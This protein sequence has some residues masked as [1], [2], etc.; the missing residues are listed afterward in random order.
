MSEDTLHET[1]V[2]LSLLEERVKF[3]E[4]SIEDLKKT[5]SGMNGKLTAI[6]VS[7]ATAALLLAIDLLVRGIGQ[8]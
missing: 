1:D 2:R 7:V 8:P 4:R 3:M 5:I 6:L